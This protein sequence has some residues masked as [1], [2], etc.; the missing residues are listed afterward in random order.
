MCLSLTFVN[1]DGIKWKMCTN[2]NSNA[3]YVSFSDFTLKA[4]QTEC[5]G[6]EILVRPSL[7][8]GACAMYCRKQ[9]RVF[10][11]GRSGTTRCDSTNGKCRC[12]CKT[13]A[14]HRGCIKTHNAGYD[15]YEFNS[16]AHL[17]TSNNVKS[18][19]FLFV[20]LFKVTLIAHYIGARPQIT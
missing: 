10:M 18:E 19:C 11:F 2:T 5:P 13:V 8:V 12:L 15:L 4:E 9:S 3:M 1:I 7:S 16:Y 14:N 6:D 20:R 17:Q